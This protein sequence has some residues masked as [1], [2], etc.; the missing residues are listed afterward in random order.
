MKKFIL[1]VNLLC[2]LRLTNGLVAEIIDVSLATQY[3]VGISGAI[4][5]GNTPVTVGGGATRQDENFSVFDIRGLDPIQ[6]ATLNFWVA[7]VATVTQNIGNPIDVKL[8]YFP[9]NVVTSENY[10]AGT[11]L[12]SFIVP[13]GG[14]PEAPGI[15]VDVSSALNDL[16]LQGADFTTMRFHDPINIIAEFEDMLGIRDPVLTVDTTVIIPEPSTYISFLLTGLFL[17]IIFH[18]R[19]LTGQS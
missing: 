8:S 18:R 7:D 3:S 1:L 4:D 19:R 16:Q 10:G 15:S 11:M 12:T 6:S 2:F 9:G 14:V 17:A 13:V 5:P